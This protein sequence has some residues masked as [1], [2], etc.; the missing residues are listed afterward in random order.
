M[1]SLTHSTFRQA[2]SSGDLLVLFYADW[3]LLSR[4]LMV[5]LEGMGLEYREINIDAESELRREYLVRAVPTLILFRDGRE[6]AC[7]VGALPERHLLR[8]LED[9]NYGCENCCEAVGDKSIVGL[10]VG[11]RR[12][13]ILPPD[14]TKR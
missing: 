3:C 6:V 9:S 7:K 4:R 5:T 10:S 1:E 13:A 8:W 2:I 14:R 12:Q 11:G